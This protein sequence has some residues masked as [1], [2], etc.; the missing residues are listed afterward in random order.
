MS[1]Y[2]GHLVRISVRT[3]SPMSWLTTWAFSIP[4]LVHRARACMSSVGIITVLA[5]VVPAQPAPSV[6]RRNPLVYQ[7]SQTQDGQTSRPDSSCSN[8]LNHHK[9]HSSFCKILMGSYYLWHG[10]NHNWKWGSHGSKWLFQDPNP[11]ENAIVHN[12]TVICH[13]FYD[14]H[15]SPQHVH[16]LAFSKPILDPARQLIQL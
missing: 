11:A 12:Q 15:L 9:I 7:K 8:D 16:H 13:L 3:E 1:G 14:K 10:G 5:V 4:I 6:S 2:C